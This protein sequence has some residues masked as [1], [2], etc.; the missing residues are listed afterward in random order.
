MATRNTDGPQ[1]F[2]HVGFDV[3]QCRRGVRH[4]QRVEIDPIQ[5]G[6][7]GADGRV[8]MGAHGL[9]NFGDGPERLGVVIDRLLDPGALAPRFGVRIEWK[10]LI[11]VRAGYVGG[12]GEGTGVGVGLGFVA[13]NITADIAQTLSRESS[14]TGGTT[15]LS[16]RYRW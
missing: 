15:Y 1:R 6:R 3:P 12:T 13:G 5:A 8:A 7:I 16:V 9:D 4:M 2:K 11:G 10:D 14:V